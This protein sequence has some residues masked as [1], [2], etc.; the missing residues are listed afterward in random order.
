MLSLYGKTVRSRLL[1]GSA[2]YPS[3]TIMRDAIKASNSEIVTV[4][5]RRESAA[6]KGEAFWSMIEDLPVSIL[7]NT[8]GCH[9]VKETVATAHMARDLFKSDWIKLE[10]IG[11]SRD[12]AARPVRA[13]RGGPHPVRGRFLRLS[14]HD[15]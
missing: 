14:L 1:I 12:L 11:G 10:V 5:L 2:L 3:P 9:T 15:R 6:G 7:P 4:S 8:A 13:C